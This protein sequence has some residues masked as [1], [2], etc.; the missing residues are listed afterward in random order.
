M[1][2]VND[3]NHLLGRVFLGSAIFVI[4]A[5]PT[6]IALV[7]ETMPDFEVVAKAMI[8]LL[9]FI[10]GGFIECISYAPLLGVSATY[11]AHI[12]GNMVN[13]KVPCAV[14]ARDNFNFPNGSPEGEVVS[15]VAVAVSTIVTTLIIA[16]GVLMLTPLTPILENPTLSPAFSVSFTALFG[17][18][19][20]KYFTPCWK[21]VPV[22]LILTLILQFTLNLGYTTLIPISA[23]VAVLTSYWMFKKEIV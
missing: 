13:L 20:Y 16:F 19:A 23:V 21:L 22:P 18:L 3:E 10:A 14:T 17:A 1:K 15:T 12:T 9:F 6:V 8:P 4:L 2:N 7:L 5:V 11:L